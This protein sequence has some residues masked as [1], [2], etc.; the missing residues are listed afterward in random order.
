MSSPS[1]LQLSGQQQPRLRVEPPFGV[2]YGDEAVFLSTAHGLTPDPWQELVIRSWLSVRG[3]G[4]WA[5]PQCGL[6]VPRQNGKNGV[7]EIRELFGLVGLGE[8]IIHTAHQVK[9]AREAFTR[10]S[11]F[12]EDAEY[13]ELSAMVKSI[14]RANG[15]EAIF[16]K[17]GGDIRFVAR[18][19]G[20]SRGL[21]ADLV[22]MDE[23]Q[24]LGDEAYEALS[25]TTAASPLGNSQKIWTGT[26]PGPGMNSEVFTRIRAEAL[27][28]NSNSI[29]WH[30][31]S[32]ERGGDLDDPENWARANPALG[33]RLNLDDLQNDRRSF[34]DEGFARERGGMWS[35]GVSAAPID[36]HSWAAVADTSSQ[37]EG[38]LSVAIDVAPD[39]R[40]GSV[41]VAGRRADGLV[42]VE[43][44][45]NRAGAGWIVDFMKAMH[46]KNPLRVIRVQG[47]NAPSAPLIEPL[48]AAGLP[49]KVTGPNDAG[50]ACASLY[51][52][53]MDRSL[54][55]LDQPVVNSSLADARQRALGTEGLWVWNRKNTSVDITPVIALTLA[56]AAVDAAPPAP[57][58]AVSNAMYGFN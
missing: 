14:R 28:G 45:E 8:R 27:E 32:I 39:N 18:S 47:G 11:G 20:G 43:L 52:S 55:H 56:A 30:E 16:L 35:D 44:V 41:A 10:L 12:F 9:T 1:A 33:T 7:I 3:D 37:I 50:A 4:K 25:P 21:T 29:S 48:E 17:N 2:S 53:V 58:H 54:R 5:S 38:R 49:V 15:Q 23:A 40:T 51:S 46:R 19:R 24:E 31:W 42:H 13:P 36:P 6:S 22:V 57:K 26:P 34:S